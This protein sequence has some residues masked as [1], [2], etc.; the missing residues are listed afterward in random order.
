MHAVSNLMSLNLLLNCV[1]NMIP[2]YE[3][4]KPMSSYGHTEVLISIDV[5]SFC[6]LEI[7]DQN[8]SACLHLAQCCNVSSTQRVFAWTG[9]S[10]TYLWM[11]CI[12]VQIKL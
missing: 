8:L 6:S 10:V 12:C 4:T 11:D 1:M 3:K 7:V 9:F 5:V 2:Q